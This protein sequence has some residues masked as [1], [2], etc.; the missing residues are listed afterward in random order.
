MREHVPLRAALLAGSA[1]RG[2]ADNYSDIDLICYV[3]LVPSQDVATD[4][5]EAVGGTKA[6][7][8]AQR[9]EHFSADEF[10]LN[11]VRVELSF[12][13]V[14]WMETRL[15]DLLERLMDLDSPSQKILSGLLEGLAMH[16]HELIERWKVRAAHYPEPLRLA[17]V[18][19]YWRFFPLWYEGAALAKRDAELWRLDMLLE[20]AFNLLGVLAGLNRLYFT[21]FQLKGT[22]AYIAKMTLAP[23][24]LAERLES[25]FRLDP[26]SAA[27]ELGRLVEETGALVAAELPEFDAGLRFPQG[28]QRQPWST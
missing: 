9:T 19:R 20:G 5:R 8:R 24:R 15:D 16:G 28:T 18:Q 4:V 10:D 23:A 13:T 2:D 14:N 26:E 17:M 22:R 25:L 11:G 21:R 6:V 27:A 12:A 1:G 3:D 7:R